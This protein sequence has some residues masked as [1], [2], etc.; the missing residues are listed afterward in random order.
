[1]TSALTDTTDGNFLGNESEPDIGQGHSIG[2][3]VGQGHS[4][5]DKASQSRPTG[6]TVG[7]GH[8]HTTSAKSTE[9]FVRATYLMIRT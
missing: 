8:A 7:Q 4:I 1:M 5:G 2:G 6:E 3:A 9:K